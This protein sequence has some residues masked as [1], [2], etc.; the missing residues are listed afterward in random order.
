MTMIT[1]EQLKEY[2]ELLK[3]VDPMKW[4]GFTMKHAAE[5]LIAEV[6]RLHGELETCHVEISNKDF[7]L[8]LMRS[9]RDKWRAKAER[10]DES[11]QQIADALHK[12]HV[13]M[14]FTG[15]SVPGIADGVIAR[16]KEL[17]AENA[18]L[19]HK[20]YLMTRLVDWQNAGYSIDEY[21]HFM[22][23]EEAKQKQR[24]DDDA[25][26]TLP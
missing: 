21:K 19:R 18:A 4:N 17:E 14:K 1:D 20:L 7:V 3:T 16:I 12:L 24:F 8:N 9:R 25:L 26:D 22:A 13:F 6:E 23:E 11:V 2:K 10:R 15:W 5:A